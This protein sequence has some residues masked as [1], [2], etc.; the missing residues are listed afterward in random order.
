MDANVVEIPIKAYLA[1]MR[2]RSTRRR[3]LPG[4]RKPAPTPATSK[5]ES[6]SRSTSSS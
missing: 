5:R 6:K 1:E 2:Q 4:Q 3:A